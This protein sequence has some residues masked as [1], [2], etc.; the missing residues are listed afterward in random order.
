MKNLFAYFNTTNKYNSIYQ[1]TMLLIERMEHIFGTHVT[2]LDFK[3]FKAHLNNADDLILLPYDS[4]KPE[5]LLIPKF[6]NVVFIYHNITPYRFFLRTEPLVA[7]R[8]ILGRIQL[9]R[10]RHISNQWVAVSEYNRREL[11]RYGFSNVVL[12][13]NQIKPAVPH[14]TEK[15]PEPSM[16]YVGRIVQNK[17]CMELL[18]IA[19]E[20]AQQIGKPT[21]LYIVGTGKPNTSYLNQFMKRIDQLNAQGILKVRWQ[22]R[23]SESELCKLYQRC[24][25]YV[26]LSQ[27]EGFGLPVCESINNGTPAIYTRCGGQELVLNNY[28][29]ADEQQMAATAHRLLSDAQALSSLY[30]QQ[31]TLIEA[32]TTPH[33]DGQIQ[34]VFAPMLK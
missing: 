21:S 20:T 29:L 2:I 33:Y 4:L 14:P 12:C 30:Q 5:I 24:W 7:L 32:I 34:Q 23:L 27:H 3:G 18:E 19:L 25:L 31:R 10:L 6:T 15:T 26:S 28:G 22:N 16:L 13:S 11:E 1:Q 17:K 9:R 8:A